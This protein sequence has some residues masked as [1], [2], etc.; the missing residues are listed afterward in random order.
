MKFTSDI[1]IDFAERQD[2]LEHIVVTPASI[3]AGGS[4]KKHN[5]GVYPTKIPVNP[6]TGLSSIDYIEAEERG[7]VKLDLLNVWVYKL[8]KSEEH[9]V[10]LMGE[11]VWSNL[12]NRSF[13]EKL[14]HIGKHYDTMRLLPEPIDSIPRLAMFL[15]L[16]RPGKRHL[17][18]RSWSEIAMEIWNPDA[19]GLYAFKKSHA[20][21]YAHLV[22]VNMNILASTT[23]VLP[24]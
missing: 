6:I 3:R 15:N 8:V 23:S 10:Q 14:I 16:I 12:Q 5:T 9:L 17:I 1:D 4:I 11:P 20:V 19:D 13:F 24:E 7:Y 21:A 2:I 22:V 18:G